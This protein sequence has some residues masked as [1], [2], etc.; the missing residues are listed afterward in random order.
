MGLFF[1]YRGAQG[2]INVV[3]KQ[4]IFVGFGIFFMFILSQPDPD[5]YKILSRVFLITSLIL[6]LITILV[7]KEINGAKRWLD[8]GVFTLQPS[9]LVKIA[10]PIYLAAYLF[11]KPIPIDL[12]N[13]FKS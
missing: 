6:V 5:I 2:N 9:E 1:L 7:A 8:L 4:G 11:E 3:M 10:L 12:K 13:T